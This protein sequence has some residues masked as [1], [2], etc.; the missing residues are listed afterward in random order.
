MTLL[1][2]AL[3]PV[4][5]FKRAV[6]REA[7]VGYSGE[8]GKAIFD[9]AIEAGHAVNGVASTSRIEMEHVPV[10]RG[11]AELLVLKVVERPGHENCAGE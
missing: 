2:D 3:A 1:D 7:D 11:D 8:R 5:A 4:V 9:L 6:E 10:G